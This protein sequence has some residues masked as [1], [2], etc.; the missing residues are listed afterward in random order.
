MNA[1]WQ[2]LKT[3]IRDVDALEWGIIFAG[4]AAIA[5]ILWSNA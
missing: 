3:D 2:Y 1:L 4:Y 5:L